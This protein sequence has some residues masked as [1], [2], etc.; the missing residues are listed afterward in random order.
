MWI[1]FAFSSNLKQDKHGSCCVLRLTVE[2]LISTSAPLY[3]FI[4]TLSSKSKVSRGLRTISAQGTNH[5]L[6]FV[7]SSIEGV[8]QHCGFGNQPYV[9]VAAPESE[10]KATSLQSGESLAEAEWVWCH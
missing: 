10:L 1:H 8:A 5:S 7:S 6:V 9:I 2:Q 4:S 3:I